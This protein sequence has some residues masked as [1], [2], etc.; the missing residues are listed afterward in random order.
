MKKRFLAFLMVLALL[1]G[2]TGGFSL[3]DEAHLA[4]ADDGTAAAEAIAE[5]KASGNMPTIVIGFLTFTG[6][7]AGTERV[8]AEMSKITE[9][10]LGIKVELHI[11]DMA[12]YAQQMNLMLASGEQ[13]DLFNTVSVGFM[14]CVSKGYL[15][16]LE[17]DDLLATY[18][19]GIID[20]FRASEL[21]GCRVAG[22]LYATPVKKDDAGGKFGMS[23]PTK[24]LDEIGVDW[25]SMYKNPDDEVIYTD[26]DFIE[27]VLGKLHEKYPDKTTFYTDPGSTVAQCLL[28]DAPG[29]QFGVLCDPVN[30]LEVTDL[31]SSDIYKELCARFYKWNQNGWISP[32]AITETNATTTQVKAGSLCAYKTATKPGIRQQESNLCGTP[33]AIFQLGQD[34]KASNTY[35]TMPWAINYGTEDPVAAMQV[36]NLLYTDPDLSTLLCWGQEGKEWVETGDGHITFPEGVDAQNSEY[37]YNVNWEMPNQFIARVW[38]GDSLDI[39]T[40]M[41][42]WN[43]N[44][45]ASKAMGFTFDNS[46]VSAEYTALTNVYNE[47]HKQLELGFVDPEVGI[48][49][50]VERLKNAGLDHY[51][52]VK[53]E[54]VNEWAA[55]NGIQ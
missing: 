40:R 12:S 28:M 16:D 18:G 41:Q 23:I 46:D 45:L 1:V 19:Q 44:A 13:V 3:A 17:E 2:L 26:F 22:T 15:L 27:D 29:D 9:E 35:S 32:D 24:Y 21:N 48:P 43:D 42:E 8:A 30:S 54:Q 11:L 55:A 20:A 14:P 6:P 53:Q 49:Q 36:L 34:F 31:F 4:K 50:F 33:V 39:W 52:S 10:K 37:Y 51:I 47:F 25:Q 5:R 38:E 7:G